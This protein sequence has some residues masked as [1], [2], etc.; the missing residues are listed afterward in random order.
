M[1]IVILATRGNIF[2]QHSVPIHIINLHKH[3]TIAYVPELDRSYDIRMVKMKLIYL[4]FFT[5]LF[6]V[7]A[8][9]GADYYVANGASCSDSWPGTESQP[10]C[11]IQKAANSARAGDNVYVKAGN[12]PE[13]VQFQNSGS[14]SEGYIVFRNYQ[15]D[16]VTL[17][18]GC[19]KGF[20]NSYINVIGFHVK[21]PP[22]EN[23]GIEFSGNGNHVEIR[24]NEVT[25]CRNSDTAAVRVG[26][27]MHHFKV[28]GNHVHHNN[29][30]T[31]EALRVHE[32]TH[33]FEITNNEID[34]NTNIGID[35]VGWAQY[36]KP[37]T[38]LVR[39]NI[40]HENSL[41]AP[42]SAGI[43]LDG[44]NNIIVEYNISWGNIRGFE[45]GCEPNGDY[46]TGNIIRYNIAYGNTESGIQVGGYQGGLVH[47]CEV[48]NNVFY[49]NGGAEIG[50]DSTPGYN[51]T[52]YNNILYDPGSS[53]IDGGGD[54]NIFQYNCYIGNGG[55]GS[56]SITDDPLFFEASQH[57]FR[58][59]QGSPCIDAGDPSTPEGKD[60]A[61]TPVPIDGNNDGTAH[62]DI[63]AY[64]YIP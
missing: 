28:D 6:Y 25:G 33:D 42:W 53:L 45:M 27:S 56:N 5:V 59:K 9:Y 35:I 14:E 37:T 39:G 32:H 43:Y 62:A 49:R 21:N 63:G 60:F 61:Q 2:R 8:C 13:T 29:T 46:S 54:Q 18:P 19:F 15:D 10:W 12:Y 55:K 23:P 17:N 3:E 36:G 48:Y 26:G 40:S 11:T 44:P 47:D 16:V 31:E 41:N 57:D 30:G 50:F 64:E 52:F 51:I 34:H 4:L 1:K 7:S 58:L 22:V 38:G 20:S 24:N